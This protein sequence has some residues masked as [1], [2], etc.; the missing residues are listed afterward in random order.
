MLLKPMR[1]AL[2]KLTYKTTLVTIA[3]I[4]VRIQNP[5]EIMTLIKSLK[6]QT[7]AVFVRLSKTSWL[8][9]SFMTFRHSLKYQTTLC[10][11]K[12]K[13]LILTT[14]KMKKMKKKIVLI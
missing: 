12:S 8:N 11:I 13:F 7:A 10:K 2:M 3:L 5:V 4:T 9:I 1:H 6:L 14:K